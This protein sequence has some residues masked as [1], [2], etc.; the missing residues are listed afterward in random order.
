[1]GIGGA[2][3]GG[4]SLLGGLFGSAPAQNVQP[5][6]NYYAP[7]AGQSIGAGFQDIQNLPGAQ[8]GQQTAPLAL[9][10][11]MNLY[12]NPFANQYQ[13]AAQGA[14]GMGQAAGLNQ[15]A[16]GGA[17]GQAGAG[18]LGLAGQLAQLGFDPQNQ[19]YQRTQGQLQDQTLANLAN[20]GVGQ[21]PY[22]QSVLG[23]TLGN[24]N[25]DWQNQQLQ[26]ALQGAQGAGQAV[27]QGGQ[28]L[29][30][31]GALQGQAPQTYLGGAGLPYGTFGQI[32]GDQLGALQN[33]QQT[34]GGAQGLLQPQIQDY[35][36]IG[37]QGQ[38]AG[39]AAANFGL[40]QANLGFQENQ[41]LGKGIGQGLGMLGPSL[42]G[43]P[44]GGGGYGT[45]GLFSGLFGR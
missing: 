19:L 39:Q 10:S 21:T 18:Q 37:Q 45:Q 1:M 14:A 34:V 4:A 35:L 12:N 13:S 29:G 40:N 16:A 32:G 38:Q 22:G 26:R 25:I 5:P 27:S 17:L 33:L 7:Y 31:M 11:G 24:F 15:F 9:Q 42:F 23:N 2:L 3:A 8:Y 30:Q 28:A 44:Y 6:P 36:G 20:A 43:S 41:A